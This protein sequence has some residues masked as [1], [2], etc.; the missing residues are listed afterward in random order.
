MIYNH[1]PVSFGTLR[2]ITA[3]YINYQYDVV[4]ILV[5][6]GLELPDYYEV[7]FCNPG[8]AQTITIVGTADGVRIPDNLLL[9]GKDV[10][11]YIV[12]QGIDEGAVETRYEVKIP[13]KKR[14][15][16]SD[17]QPTPSERLEIDELVSALN[18]GVARAEDA[19][20]EAEQQAQNAEESAN[21]SEESALKSEGFAVGE[22]NGKAV[23]QGS[24]YYQNNSKFYA[25]VAQQGAEA[26]G[27]AWFDVND[28]DGEMY[29]TITPNLAEDVSFLVNE[30][31]GTL[32]VTVHG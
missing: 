1:I 12:I 16:R 22:Q 29:V 13:V 8:D 24:P 14:P 32:E 2:T 15:A 7:D 6:N 25:N 27:F 11:A 21:D 31:M 23:G 20:E 5:I 10:I 28:E 30:T 4:Q 19:V 3:P 18:D 17:I 9:T 26:S